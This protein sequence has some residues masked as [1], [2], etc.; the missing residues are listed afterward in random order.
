MGWVPPPHARGLRLHK[1]TSRPRARRWLRVWDRGAETGSGGQAALPAQQ[2]PAGPGQRRV[3]LGLWGQWKAKHPVSPRSPGWPPGDLFQLLFLP[4]A[5]LGVWGELGREGSLSSPCMQPLGTAG[6]KSPCSGGF[7]LAGTW[8]TWRHP[9]SPHRGQMGCGESRARARSGR[10]SGHRRLPEAAGGCDAAGAPQVSW[11]R[12]CRAGWELNFEQNEKPPLEIPRWREGRGRFL[13]GF[14]KGWGRGW[15]PEGDSPSRQHLLPDEREGRK[16]SAC[17]C[18]APR[19]ME[20]A[21]LLL[22]SALWGCSGECPGA[23]P[24]PRLL[25]QGSA[26]RATSRAPLLAPHPCTQSCGARGCCVCDGVVL[27]LCAARGAAALPG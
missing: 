27:L 6:V 23:V 25:A 7:L 10:V 5:P 20:A 17:C 13:Q 11:A 26:P 22:L 3:G 19:A 16:T 12:G 21:P 18:L 4:G 24:V 14:K 2:G 9:G 15:Q 8:G 1:F